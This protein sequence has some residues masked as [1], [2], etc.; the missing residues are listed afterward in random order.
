MSDSNSAELVYRMLEI[1]LTPGL[2]PREMAIKAMR[3]SRKY[4]FSFDDDFDELLAKHDL[5]RTDTRGYSHS[6]LRYADEEGF[7]QALPFQ[8]LK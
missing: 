3:V 8:H 7:D 2:T 1:M 5:V 6:G 4:D